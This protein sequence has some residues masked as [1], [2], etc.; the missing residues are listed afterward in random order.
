VYE[1]YGRKVQLV[2]INGSGTSTDEVAA[3]AD[4]DQAAADGVF[5]VMG[6]PTQAESFETEL[7]RKHILCLGSCV[8]SSPASTLAE[9]ATVPVGDRSDTGTDRVDDHLAHQSAA[10]G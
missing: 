2:R 6:G 10:V 4:A 7:A 9:D 8:I 3:K 1:L 5:A